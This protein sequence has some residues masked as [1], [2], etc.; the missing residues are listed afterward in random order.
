MSSVFREYTVEELEEMETLRQSHGQ[1]L[2][3]DEGGF[4]VWLERGDEAPTPVTYEVLIAGR[5]Y[6]IEPGEDGWTVLR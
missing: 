6:P 2:K 1:D 4:S 5:W 3:V